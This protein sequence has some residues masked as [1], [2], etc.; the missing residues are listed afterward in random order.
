MDGKGDDY[1]KSEVEQIIHPYLDDERYFSDQW[2]FAHYLPGNDIEPG[3]IEY[4]VSPPDYWEPAQKKRVEKHFKDFEIALRF[5]KEAGPRLAVLMNQ[6]KEL[7]D[8]QVDKAT[9]KHIIFQSVINASPF[10]NHWER[11]MCATLMLEL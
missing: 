3:A 7:L 11:V 10:I 5:S 1:A 9:S 2:I 8:N 4:F 6:Y